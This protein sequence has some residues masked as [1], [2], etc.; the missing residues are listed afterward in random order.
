M[1]RGDQLMSIMYDALT[2]TMARPPNSRGPY[3]IE[4]PEDAHPDIGQIA[5]VASVLKKVHATLPNDYEPH[6]HEFRAA[7]ALFL[8]LMQEER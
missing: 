5:K 6:Q 1:G 2:N 3:R 8:K 4:F 7:A